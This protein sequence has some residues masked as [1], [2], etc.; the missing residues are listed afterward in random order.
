MT[1]RDTLFID[2]EWRSP[3]SRVTI[4]V[5]SPSTE[6]VIGTVPDAD[7]SD[8][9]SAVSAA[10]AAFGAGTWRGLPISERARILQLALQALEPKI[11]DIA[12]L[13]TAE[14]GLP[15]SI[16]HKKIPGALAAGRYF[17]DLAVNDTLTEVRQTM[18]GP[19]AVVKEP[20]GVVAAVAPWNGPFNMAVAKIFPALV[21][22]CSV[23]YKPA[24]ETPLDAYFIAEALAAAGLPPG[25][26]NLVTGGRATGRSLVTHPKVNKVSF[27]GSTAAGRQIVSEAG[28][29][30]TRL[31]LELGGKSAA[32]VLEDADVE[33]TMRGIAM[34]SFANTG[35]VCSAFSRI[36]V[37]AAHRD[38]WIDAIVETAESFVVGDPFDPATTMGPLVSANQRD[39]VLDYVRIGT[40]EGAVVATGGGAPEGDGIGYYVQPTVLIDTVNSMRVCQE[41]IFGPVVTV[42]THE[43]VDEA[44]AIANDS[45]Y[46]LH[47]GVF[48]SDPHAAAHVARSV[49][50]GTFSVNS[51]THN[52]NAPFGGVKDSGIGRELGREGIQSYYEIKTVNLT[53][54][55]ETLFA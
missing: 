51:Y 14:M 33:T 26:F 17:L 1:V 44:I 16:A 10:S 46:G 9:D 29:R 8:V 28:P 35:Q 25:V 40:A 49:H 11:A 55:T 2:G 32:I 6:K 43:S 54:D 20:V 22:G 30:F 48:T 19:A 27:T 7:D 52:H 45:N 38:K 34:G 50:T 39:R 31:Q 12:D 36:V 41:E 21:T 18:W 37:P 24:P 47:G 15:T 23:V 4:D 3:H 53:E 5:V 42:L 13:V